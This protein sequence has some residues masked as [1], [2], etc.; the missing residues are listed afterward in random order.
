MSLAFEYD[1]F[2]SF[3]STDDEIAKPIW[4]EMCVNGLRV[5]WSDATL[6]DKIGESW[7]EVIQSSLENSRH[8][9]L[10]CSTNSMESEW[11]KREYK[12]FFN[13][14]YKA[15]ARRLIPVLVKNYKLS[16]LPLF[17]R[18]LEACRLT[19]RA[20]IKKLI[21]ILG[22]TDINELKKILGE[23]NEEN[24]NLKMQIDIANYQIKSLDQKI[25]KT[26]TEISNLKD[27]NNLL[28]KDIKVKGIENSRLKIEINKVLLRLKEYANQ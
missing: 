2:L 6:K 19:E 25:T 23:K 15:G 26:S 16:D 7:F 13:H 9:V 10:L 21:K 17:L 20:S 3:A 11:V 8:F 22:G 28:E 24:K 27:V 12:A 1:V 5:F 18:E 4:Q 14:C